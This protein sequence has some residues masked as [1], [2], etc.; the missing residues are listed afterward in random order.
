MRNHII[1]G[2]GRCCHLKH[3][4]F[5]LNQPHSHAHAVHSHSLA[6]HS[7]S[8]SGHGTPALKKNGSG[9]GFHNKHFKPLRFKM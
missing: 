1:L 3:I 2:R 9:E 7:H 5:S 6:V 8:E 4:K